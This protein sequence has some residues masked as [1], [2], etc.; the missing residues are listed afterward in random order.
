MY[1]DHIWFVAGEIL[2]RT[3]ILPK[4]HCE[5]RRCSI[6][7]HILLVAFESKFN[8]R[9]HS[10][11]AHPLVPKRVKRSL[12]ELML[13]KTDSIKDR[14]QQ[15]PETERRLGIIEY[16]PRDTARG[17]T[18]DEIQSW[19]GSN[20]ASVLRFQSLAGAFFCFTE[21]KKELNFQTRVKQGFIPG[22]YK[23]MAN[24]L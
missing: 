17:A 11:L 13:I 22:G 6:L 10:F 21:S 18:S 1:T 16:T 4:F 19:F 5:V 3:V 12:S 20:Q 9:E 23:Q 7:H 14:R 24:K 2:N 8:Y 15:I